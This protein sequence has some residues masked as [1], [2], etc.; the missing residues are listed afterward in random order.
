MPTPPNFREFSQSSALAARTSKV[1]SNGRTLLKFDIYEAGE[2]SQGALLANLRTFVTRYNVHQLKKYTTRNRWL[3]F[4]A[5][6]Q[7]HI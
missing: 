4:A 1:D 6:F 2:L 3:S 5:S 7:T